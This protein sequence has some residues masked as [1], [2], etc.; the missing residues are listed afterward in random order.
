MPKRNA[1]SGYQD[2]IAQ[3]EAQVR[4]YQRQEILKP[5]VEEFLRNIG[6][7]LA[8]TPR[9]EWPNIANVAFKAAQRKMPAA[10]EYYDLPKSQ[11]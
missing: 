9:A 4:K 6:V 1:F 7:I 10:A 2:R 11:G 5:F 3:L 8:N